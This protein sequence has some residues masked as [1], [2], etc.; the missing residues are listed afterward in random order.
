MQELAR[1]LLV[2]ISVIRGKKIIQIRKSFL[3]NLN[4]GKKQIKKALIKSFSGIK[5]L[6]KKKLAQIR[7]IAGIAATNCTN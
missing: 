3:I 7:M 4:C 1:I 2:E 5:V 6:N